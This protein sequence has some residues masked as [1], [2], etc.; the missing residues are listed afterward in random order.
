MPR[1]LVDDET[2]D[3]VAELVQRLC[4]LFAEL[5]RRG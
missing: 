2:A 5:D 4:E 1:T 3:S